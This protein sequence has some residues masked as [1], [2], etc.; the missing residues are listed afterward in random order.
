[1]KKIIDYYALRARKF[2][3]WYL[4]GMIVTAS[5]EALENQ[6]KVDAINE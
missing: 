1:M 2:R 3:D 6:E 5:N 4:Q